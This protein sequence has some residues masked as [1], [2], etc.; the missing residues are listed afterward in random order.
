MVRRRIDKGDGPRNRKVKVHWNGRG[1]NRNS[2]R[3]AAPARTLDAETR[4]HAE[5][6]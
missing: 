6:A 2:R 5:Q 4:E 1:Q 3:A